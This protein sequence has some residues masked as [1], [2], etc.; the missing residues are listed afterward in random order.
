[1]GFHFLPFHVWS[2]SISSRVKGTR[3]LPQT[4]L[5]EIC[6]S[7]AQ[8]AAVVPRGWWRPWG[9]QGSLTNGEEE[10]GGQPWMT[11]R[12]AF[13]GRGTDELLTE[14]PMGACDPSPPRSS[15][16]RGTPAVVTSP[17]SCRVGGRSG[18]VHA[19]P[20]TWLTA[21]AAGA[22]I[23]DSGPH[24]QHRHL[25]PV[26]D[27]AGTPGDQDRASELVQQPHLVGRGAEAGGG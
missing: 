22:V 3:S 15:V 19:G 14:A 24:H 11:R 1:M 25:Q 26:S 13:Q 12:L 4:L 2:T 17:P 6:S 27:D 5:S 23:A 9:E 18:D 7:V 20:L 16:S 21:S 8:V 10:A